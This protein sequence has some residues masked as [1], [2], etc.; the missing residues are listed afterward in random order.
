MGRPSKGLR[1]AHMVKMHPA[2]VARLVE[3]AATAGAS[4]VSQYAADVLA[5]HVGLPGCVVELN[6][7]ALVATPVREPRGDS[8]G[9]LMIRPHPTVSQRLGLEAVDKGLP[10][11]IAPYIHD[12]LAMHVGLPELVRKSSGEEVLQLAM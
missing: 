12:V 2:V 9:R 3:K 5:L 6:Q 7:P 4:S 10:P 1:G 8:R 11:Q